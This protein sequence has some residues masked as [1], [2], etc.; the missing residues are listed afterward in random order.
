[1]AIQISPPSTDADGLDEL[2]PLWK[3]LHRHHREVANYRNLVQD[4]DSSWSRRLGWYRRLLAQGAAYVTAADNG[5]RL[6]GY[7][8]VALESGPDDT[9]D[10]EG[11]IAEVVTLVVAA[12]QRS[13]GVGAALLRAAENIA[14]DR[15]FDTVKIAV[16]S[17]NARAQLFYEANGYSVGEHL[18]YQRLGDQ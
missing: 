4:L 17:G 5:G 9:F 10:V 2:A 13:A 1:M 6:I 14:R 16:M 8:M 7:A 11:G 3:E 15:G 18:L 12:D